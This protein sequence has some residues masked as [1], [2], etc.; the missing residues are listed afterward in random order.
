MLGLLYLG[1][2]RRAEITAERLTQD[3]TGFLPGFQMPRKPQR[4]D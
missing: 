3:A 2:Y 1:S 4:L